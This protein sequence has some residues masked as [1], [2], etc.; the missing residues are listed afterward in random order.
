MKV[1]HIVLEKQVENNCHFF[2]FHIHKLDSG[3][4]V[5]I[6]LV[7]LET[8]MIVPQEKSKITD[9]LRAFGE[10]SFLQWL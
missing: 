4:F 3:W 7:E 1:C 2:K 6:G 8:D 10:Q 5:K 9:L